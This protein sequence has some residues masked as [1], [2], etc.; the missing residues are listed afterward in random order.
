MH[1][2]SDYAAVSPKRGCVQQSD[3]VKKRVGR[4]SVSRLGTTETVYTSLR[5]L[6]FS[7]LDDVFLFPTNLTT[8]H[9]RNVIAVGAQDRVFM[10]QQ[11]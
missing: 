2:G 1:R 6:H 9:V 7:S 4:I 5:L 8:I 11:N 3:I 10:K